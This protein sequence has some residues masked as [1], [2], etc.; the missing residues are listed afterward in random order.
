VNYCPRGYW[1]AGEKKEGGGKRG[2]AKAGNGVRVDHEAGRNPCMQGISGGKK[3]KKKKQEESPHPGSAAESGLR[4]V[5][6]TLI[7]HRDHHPLEKKRKG[8]EK[9]G[10]GKRGKPEDQ[11]N[12]RASTNSSLLPAAGERGKKKGRGKKNRGTISP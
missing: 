7:L 9:R 6:L 3:R 5:S 12:A 8:G 10:R 11:D 1:T 4:A 2:E